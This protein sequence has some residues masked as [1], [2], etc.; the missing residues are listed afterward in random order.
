MRWLGRWYEVVGQMINMPKLIILLFISNK[1]FEMEKVKHS[2]HNNGKKP[3]KYLWI[4][5]TRKPQDWYEK[6]Y[7][8]LLKVVK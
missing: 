3:I 1:H 8:T 7:K 5:L 2:T 6:D 4:N